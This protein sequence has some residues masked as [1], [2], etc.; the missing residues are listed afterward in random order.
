VPALAR[1]AVLHSAKNTAVIAELRAI[2]RAAP[3]LGVDIVP[4]SVD[5]AQE[6]DLALTK[7]L[8]AGVQG[9]VVTDDPLL[10]SE[11]QRIIDFAA[12]YKLPAIYG[13]G[14]SVQAGGL[15][16]YGASI[17]EMWRHA[18][19]YVDRILKGTNPADI[20]VE[21]PTVYEFRINLSTARALGLTLPESLL[22]RADEVIE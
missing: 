9:L 1:A 3:Q 16:S 13:I 10:D 5:A 11:Q 12:R 15:M 8:A 6:L 7:V 22:T 20:P 14:V 18:A 4:V 19:S 21:Q 17:F 2:E